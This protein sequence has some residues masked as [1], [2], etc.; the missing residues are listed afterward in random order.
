MPALKTRTPQ[1][2]FNAAILVAFNDPANYE[3]LAELSRS[4]SNPNAVHL[5]FVSYVRRQITGG[6]IDANP[7]ILR[8]ILFWLGDSFNVPDTDEILQKIDPNIS[9]ELIDRHNEILQFALHYE[10]KANDTIS[11][12]DH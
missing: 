8:R 6:F 2:E 11:E 3:I 1:E 12:Y 5:E 4:A 9:E 10:H 7:F